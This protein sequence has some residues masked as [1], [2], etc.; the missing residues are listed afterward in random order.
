MPSH[1]PITLLPNGPGLVYSADDRSSNHTRAGGKLA[2]RLSGRDH[3]RVFIGI[4]AGILFGSGQKSA[5]R[6]PL[7][8]R[9]LI[10]R[11]E[12]DRVWKRNIWNREA[13]YP[14]YSLRERV[15][16]WAWIDMCLHTC[17]NAN[18]TK[19]IQSCHLE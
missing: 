3:L 19:I 5:P 17:A 9:R 1:A 11:R 10:P 8:F 2:A 15:L 13:R 7:Q 14:E 12:W 16:D 6:Y 4:T 18:E